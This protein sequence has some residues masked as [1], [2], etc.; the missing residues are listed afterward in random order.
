MSKRLRAG[1]HWRRL[2]FGLSTLLNIKK[3][4]FFIPYRY[5]ADLVEPKTYGALEP[6]FAQGEVQ[7]ERFLTAAEAHIDHLVDFSRAPEPHP[8][9]NQDWFPGLDA[10]AAYTI[11]RKLKPARIVE[12]GS[13]HST[14]FLSLAV[15]DENISTQIDTIDPVPRADIAALPSV[16]LH[17]HL[18]QDTPD[19][20]WEGLGPNDIVSLDGSHIL[21]PGT[22]VDMFLTTI[23]PKIAGNPVLHIHDMTLPDAYPADWAW[24]GYNEQGA[25]AGLIASGAYEVLWSSHYVATRM[26]SRLERSPLRELPRNKHAIETSLWLTPSRN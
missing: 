21:A 24:R 6:L 12:V 26:E 4:G 19:T 10:I 25:M 11:V 5:A 15:Q 7:F 13:G 3:L 22:D 23:L 9:L 17:Q 14:R 18:V 2:R 16:R 1:K 20:L 8:R